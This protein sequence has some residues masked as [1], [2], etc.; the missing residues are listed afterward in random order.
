MRSHLDPCQ[1]FLL[2]LTSEVDSKGL[3]I[4][5]QR[6]IKR[7]STLLCWLIGI[8]SDSSYKSC[9]QVRSKQVRSNSL[10]CAIDLLQCTQFDLFDPSIDSM[11]NCL[12]NYQVIQ[13]AIYLP[14]QLEEATYHPGDTLPI[15]AFTPTLQSMFDCLSINQSV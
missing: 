11:F 4:S 14:N 1:Q 9:K 12:P 13:L 3:T 15:K 2:N 8:R 5:I 6:S 10:I 7:A